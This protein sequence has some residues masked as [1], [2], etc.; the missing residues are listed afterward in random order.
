MD[1]SRKPKKDILGNI[2]FKHILA[3]LGIVLGIGT[4]IYRYA[5]LGW[6]DSV[7]N[8]S[9]ILS[10]MG[11]VDHLETSSGKLMASAYA[12][13]CGAFLLA[14]IAFAINKLLVKYAN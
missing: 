5:G 14:V 9:M 3:G 1:S 10:S 4:L 13:F 8:A 7:Y 12:I 6:V 2:T 11:P